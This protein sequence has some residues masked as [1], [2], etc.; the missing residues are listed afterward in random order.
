M[1]DGGKLKAGAEIGE[2]EA[3]KWLL[4]ALVLIAVL[5]AEGLVETERKDK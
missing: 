2:S 4:I 5:V 1:R 3:M